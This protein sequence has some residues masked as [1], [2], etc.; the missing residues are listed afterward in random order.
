MN[1]YSKRALKTTATV[2]MSL[3]MVLSAAAP[4]MAARETN[5]TCDAL[6]PGVHYGH[7][8][9]LDELVAL[10]L[11]EAN[12]D[13]KVDL[14]VGDEVKLSA[15]DS[16]YTGALDYFVADRT[17]AAWLCASS[18]TEYTNTK[19]SAQGIKDILALFGDAGSIKTKLVSFATAKVT[20]DA[21][22]KTA[23]DFIKFFVDNVD[24]LTT[25]E[26]AMADSYT[27]RAE[28]LIATYEKD[29]VDADS[30]V[31][32]IGEIVEK[33]TGLTDLDDATVYDIKG[34][35]N[36]IDAIDD[37]MT[38][39]D[40]SWARDTKVK[41]AIKGVNDALDKVNELATNEDALEDITLPKDFNITGADMK[42]T[43]DGSSDG[44]EDTSALADNKA[45]IEALVDTI[46][47]D[48]YKVLK[49]F[50]KVF[51]KSWTPS[52]EK[53]TSRA[54]YKLYF[55]EADVAAN[56]TGDLL[57]FANVYYTPIKKDG[58]LTSDLVKDLTEDRMDEVETAYN[59]VMK[60]ATLTTKVDDAIYELTDE[61]GMYVDNL[62]KAE[63]SNI[64]VKA[65]SLGKVVGTTGWV[66]K[67]NGD[68]TYT[69]E[70]GKAVTKWVAAGKDWY[71]VK[72]GNML[73][74]AWVAQDATGA[75][76]Y[77]VDNA[78]KMVSNTT[79]D[80]FVIDANGVWTK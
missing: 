53:E 49:A 34:L 67:G 32:K 62:T 72:G 5:G 61:D 30:I 59:L 31:V 43:W 47:S 38:T 52:L 14:T 3:A 44:E 74:N 73:R 41:K 4:V 21:T 40:K 54:E 51:L 25:K 26:Q 6:L 10:D 50:D 15:I 20:D 57:D 65:A 66:D 55:D 75:K 77:Y 28:K 45:A 70:S 39:I 79:I 11:K 63:F 9:L 35:E 12:N 1:K 80:G 29:A 19:K 68:W 71:Y 46:D 42:I 22:K 33:N 24:H 17:T 2:G 56:A 8:D 23:E 60:A 76:W 69:D 13:T 58:K 27:A 16:K 18:D 36:A 78:G 37:Y 7:K 48:D 64:F